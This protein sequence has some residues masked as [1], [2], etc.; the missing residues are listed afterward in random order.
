[1][2]FVVYPCEEEHLHD[3]GRR[4]QRLLLQPSREGRGTVLRACRYLRN[5]AT[6]WAGLRDLRFHRGRRS[7]ITGA[8]GD[9]L[10]IRIDPAILAIRDIAMRAGSLY[11]IREDRRPACRWTRPAQHDGRKAKAME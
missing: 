6:R 10:K 8:D 9:L 3:V 5:S 11:A 7:S 4:V 2:Q 1:M